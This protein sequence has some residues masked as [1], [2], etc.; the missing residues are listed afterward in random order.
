MYLHEYEGSNPGLML[1][2][3]SAKI[4]SVLGFDQ[5]HLLSAYSTR[6]GTLI[7]GFD[8]KIGDKFADA[9]EAVRVAISGLEDRY[10][11][12]DS[13]NFRLVIGKLAVEKGELDLQ[14]AA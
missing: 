7:F 5:D 10:L 14:S 2:I 6:H 3:L 9:S 8:P 11:T 4:K 13:A 12:E 1:E